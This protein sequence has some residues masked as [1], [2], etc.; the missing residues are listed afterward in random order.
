MPTIIAANSYEIAL[1][2]QVHG[3]SI[4]RPRSRPLNNNPIITKNSNS[5]KNINIYTL[6]K[7]RSENSTKMQTL[8]EK[9]RLILPVPLESIIRQVEHI[10]IVCGMPCRSNA[11][12]ATPKH[13]VTRNRHRH[14]SPIPTIWV[15]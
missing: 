4:S 14:H 1:S 6:E 2:H 10:K 12:L 7:K 15:G 3:M 11:T 8:K 9:E 13:H 5:T